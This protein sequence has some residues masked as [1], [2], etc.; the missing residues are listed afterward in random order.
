MNGPLLVANL[1]SFRLELPF[2]H[3]CT[4]SWPTPRSLL[5]RHQQSG[6]LQRLDDV[7]MKG[8]VVYPLFKNSVSCGVFLGSRYLSRVGQ[9]RYTQS[10]ISGHA[11]AILCSTVED[12]TG[13]ELDT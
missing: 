5:G 12:S 9:H 3:V 13:E 10:G 2:C 4:A 11:L 8:L 7:P 6:T 1:S